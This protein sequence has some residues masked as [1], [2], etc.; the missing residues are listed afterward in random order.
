MVVVVGP[1]SEDFASSLADEGHAVY[2]DASGEGEGEGEGEERVALAVCDATRWWGATFGGG[3]MGRGVVE[4]IHHALRGTSS[5]GLAISVQPAGSVVV[6]LGVRSLDPIEFPLAKVS[7]ATARHAM[8]VTLRS[9]VANGV[10]FGPNAP[11]ALPPPPS[12]AP[13]ST[14][15]MAMGSFAPGA[16]SAVGSSGGS[17]GSEM[18][19]EAVVG[20]LEEVEKEVRELRS[21]L[22]AAN[23]TLANNG[24]APVVGGMG[25]GGMGGDNGA[26]K[27]GKGGARGG[28]R[29]AP[30]NLINPNARRTKKAK[31]LTLKKKKTKS[32]S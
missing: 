32:K 26:G 10:L 13:S 20:Q 27:G 5:E 11:P 9:V 17:G 23:A 18:M 6:T 31:G 30:Q 4:R 29:R 25:V 28:K 1:A 14:S 16:S 21:Q 22:A 15:Q 24:L 12:V 7:K 3:Q 19:M 2:D 8:A